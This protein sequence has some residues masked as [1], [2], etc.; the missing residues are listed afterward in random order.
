MALW[1]FPVL[2]TLL[3]VFSAALSG[4]C[5]LARQPFIKISFC[6]FNMKTFW[7]KDTVFCTDI[8]N[9]T[10]RNKKV[11]DFHRVNF[12]ILPRKLLSVQFHSHSLVR[13]HFMAWVDQI[14]DSSQKRVVANERNIFH[15]I[16]S[17]L[18]MDICTHATQ[19]CLAWFNPK[20]CSAP[21]DIQVERR[22]LSKGRPAL[23]IFKILL[24][25]L[26]LRY[27]LILFHKN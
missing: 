17:S 21:Q 23:F 7:G 22:L 14:G 15:G 1:W 24:S 3:L 25:H 12:V 6:L 9:R 26:I 4:S 10:L 20:I 5:F 18:I 27:N 8:F 16:A 19:H 11:P 2:R 13:L